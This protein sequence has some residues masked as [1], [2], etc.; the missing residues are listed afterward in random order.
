MQDRHALLLHAWP[1]L[2]RSGHNLNRLPAKKKG[3]WAK[4]RPPVAS[5]SLE[6]DAERHIQEPRRTVLRGQRTELARGRNVG[7]RDAA[8]AKSN[9]L[10]LH[11]VE[12][13][14]RLHGESQLHPL[15]NADVLADRGIHVPA[16]EAPDGTCAE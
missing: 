10:E 8:A 11:V 9:V 14:H 12:H 4:A 7:A 3:G 1:A 13:V 16:V 6:V 5:K 2:Y 15:G